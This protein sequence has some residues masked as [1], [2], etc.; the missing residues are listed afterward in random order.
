MGTGCIVTILIGLLS[1]LCFGPVGLI[2]FLI[3]LCLI[4]LIVAAKG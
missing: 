4:A 1:L 3:L 2:V